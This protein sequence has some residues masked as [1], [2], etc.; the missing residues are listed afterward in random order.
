M[1]W[2][3]RVLSSRAR[4]SGLPGCCPRSIAAS[5]GHVAKAEQ[6]EHD[7]NISRDR[8]VEIVG[9]SVAKRVEALSLQLYSKVSVLT[10]AYCLD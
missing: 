9:E 8:A 10:M 3:K 1:Y 7:E 5:Q 4:S 6:G 2:P